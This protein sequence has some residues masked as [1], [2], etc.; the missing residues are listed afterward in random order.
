[1]L[2]D[3]FAAAKGAA[4]GHTAWVGQAVLTDFT[5]EGHFARRSEPGK[6]RPSPI[7]CRPRQRRD[8]ELAL[9]VQPSEDCGNN[10]SPGRGALLFGYS[11][12]S[13]DTIHDGA[14]RLERALSAHLPRRSSR[15]QNG[16]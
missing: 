12:F 11:A 13:E 10:A 15:G 14:R 7:R 2:V 6:I 4:V 1:M 3:V 9:I 16:R 8:D 5:E